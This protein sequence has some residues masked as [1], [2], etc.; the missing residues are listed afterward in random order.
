VLR[1]L[2]VAMVV[3][4][5]IDRFG[6]KAT[7]RSPRHRSACAVVAEALGD[8]HIERGEK[9]VEKIWERYGRA[10]PTVPGWAST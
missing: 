4:A 5:V 6:L 7:G 2:Y 10:M 3:A 8:V 9:S 1:D